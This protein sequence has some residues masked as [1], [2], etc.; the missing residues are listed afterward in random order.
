MKAIK[1]TGTSQDGLYTAEAY[2]ELRLQLSTGDFHMHKSSIVDVPD[3]A[4]VIDFGL[5]EDQDGTE[6]FEFVVLNERGNASLEVALILAGI[7]FF[8]AAVLVM[9]VI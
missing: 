2:A 3:D 1:V 9:G 5:V 7:A 8:P 6:S 4:E